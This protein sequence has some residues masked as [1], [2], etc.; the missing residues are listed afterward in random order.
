M[1]MLSK[2]IWICNK[3]HNKP[4]PKFK[5]R[6][7]KD[8]YKQIIQIEYEVDEEDVNKATFLIFSFT[9]LIV[10]LISLS[11][12]L[13][14]A[15]STLISLIISFLFS[16]LFNNYLYKKMFKIE[17]RLNAVLY[18]IK[19]NYSMIR[20]SLENNSDFILSFVKLI[21]NYNLPIS[22]NFESVLIKIHEGANP[23]R[24]LRKIVTP[25]ADFNDYM[26]NLLIRTHL[27][28]NHFYE[29]DNMLERRFKVY[30]RQIETRMSLVFFIGVFFPLGLCFLI[31][32]Y[33]D[34]INLSIFFVPIFFL[35]VNYLFKV[36]IKNDTFLFGLLNDY[37]KVEKRKF[38]EFTYFLKIFALHLQENIS[39]ESAFI[40]AFSTS[41]NQLELLCDPIKHQICMLLNLSCPFGDIIDLLKIQMKSVRYYLI[42]DIIKHIVISN[43]FNSS[44]KIFGILKIISNH[45]KLEKKLETVMKGEKFKVFMFLFLLPLIIGTIG[46]MFP[47]FTLLVNVKDVIINQNLIALIFSSDFIIIFITLLICILISSYFFLKTIN[48]SRIYECLILIFV[49]YTLLFL[50]SFFNAFN[51]L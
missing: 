29:V 4:L 20:E 16:Y 21:K 28:E 41:R 32:F 36:L 38:L 51:F 22:K 6:N 44:K 5:F 27:N 31:M 39:P 34:I 15:F 8:R 40:N 9:F 45:Q 46:G 3:L 19:I 43:A 11:I 30:L 10:I 23:E 2:Y 1:K 50:F 48:S 14:L 25:S 7:L 24:E 49:I 12:N 13:N 47:I 35:I 42:L 26:K 33:R 17:V 37:K 18:F